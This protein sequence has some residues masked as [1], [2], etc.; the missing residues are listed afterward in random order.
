MLFFKP[1]VKADKSGVKQTLNL[2]LK[3]DDDVLMRTLEAMAERVES[4]SILAAIKIPVMIL[5]GEHDMLTPPEKSA[6]MQQ[7]IQGSVLHIIENSGHLGHLEN[8]DAFNQHLNNFLK[9]F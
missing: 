8:K 5:C 6:F 7:Q 9:S 4:C 1:I 2:M 3:A